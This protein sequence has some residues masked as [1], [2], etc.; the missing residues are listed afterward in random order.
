MKNI[1]LWFVELYPVASFTGD[2]LTYQLIQALRFLHKCVELN[3]LPSY[4]IPERN[5]FAD[6]LHRVQRIQLKTFLSILIQE[7]GYLLLRCE[8]LRNGMT[9]LYREPDMAEKYRKCM[10]DM[11]EKLWLLWSKMRTEKL[12]T[13]GLSEE[14][15]D[16]LMCTDG[17]NGRMALPLLINVY[18]EGIFLIRQGCSEEAFLNLFKKRM[19]QMLS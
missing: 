10:R 6:R 2:L 15:V 1:V 13:T 5:L 12:A 7:R 18:P 4:M 17:I 3:F 8:Q 19:L 16:V 9:I 14:E 11:T